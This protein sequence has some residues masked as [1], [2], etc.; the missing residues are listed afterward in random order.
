MNSLFTVHLT[1]NPSLQILTIISPE[2][3]DYR[4]NVITTEAEKTFYVSVSIARRLRGAIALG[5]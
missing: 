4:C 2:G 1:L 3:S 5:F